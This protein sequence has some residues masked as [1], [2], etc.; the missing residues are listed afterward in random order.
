M[1]DV[2]LQNIFAFVVMDLLL[3]I[4]LLGGVLPPHMIS[5]YV[6]ICSAADGDQKSWLVLRDLR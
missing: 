2:I 6:C 3:I 5:A 4:L 1:I